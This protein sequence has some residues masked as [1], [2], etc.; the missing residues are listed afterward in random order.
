MTRPLNLLIPMAG[1]GKRFR[2]AGYDTYKPFLPIFG[3]PMIQYV[4][5]AFPPHVTRRVLADRSLLTDEQLD[6]LTRQPGV[7]VHFVPSHELGP[8]YSI[9][10]GWYSQLPADPAAAPSA[11]ERAAYERTAVDLLTRPR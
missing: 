7:I 3:K 1:Q 6:F 11:R 5:D 9:Y 8:A 4:L 2:R 10:L